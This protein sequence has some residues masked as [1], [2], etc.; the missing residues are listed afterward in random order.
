[1]ETLIRMQSHLI[2]HQVGNNIMEMLMDKL[3]ITLFN[4][5]YDEMEFCF[6]L[7]VLSFSSQFRSVQSKF[8]DF[9]FEH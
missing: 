1:M 8:N 6:G 3:K 5:N 9:E 7:V 4:Q 2:I